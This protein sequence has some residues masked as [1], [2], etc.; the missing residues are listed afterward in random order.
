MPSP[1]SNYH[2]PIFIIN[3]YQ[4]YSCH[5]EQDYQV[6]SGEQAGDLSDAADL[7]WLGCSLRA[8]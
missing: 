3:Q 1:F 6:L 7:Y 2:P 5:V 4:I 8:F